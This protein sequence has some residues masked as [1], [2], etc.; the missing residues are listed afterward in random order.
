MAREVTD[1]KREHHEQNLFESQER[2]RFITDQVSDMI[3]THDVEG[4]WTY[5][6]PALKRVLGYDAS[7]VI[8]QDAAHFIHPDDKELALKAISSALKTPGVRPVTY[9]VR[10]KSGVYLWLESCLQSVR[11]SHTDRVTEIVAVSRDINR[12]KLEEEEQRKIMYRKMLHVQQT[13]LAVIEFTPTGEVV[14]WNPSAEQMFGWSR[15]QIV[16]KHFSIFVPEDQREEIDEVWTGLI[17]QSGGFRKAN[18]NIRSDGRRILCEWYNTPLIDADGTTVGVASLVQDVTDRRVA[19]EL[20]ENQRLQMVAAS[21]MS[22]LGEMAAGIAHEI[23]NPLAIILARAE[24]LRAAAERGNLDLGR[25]AEIS[26]RISATSDRIARIVSGLRFFARDGARD[27]F[28]KKPVASLVEETIAFC[29][30]RF[31]NH[32]VSL[33]MIPPE[34]AVTIECRPVQ[35]SQVLLNLLNNAFDAIQELPERWIRIAWRAHGDEVEIRI[36]D[37][38]PGIPANIADRIMTPFFTT[39]EIGKGT[40]LGLS[41]SRGIVE[42]H[43]GHLELVR[44]TAHTTFVIRLP[45]RQTVPMPSEHRPKS[46]H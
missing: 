7:E 6:N 46:I 2:Y 12:R 39:K 23:N 36:S 34:S 9:R 32:K 15:E 42:S 30:S 24:Q 3:H 33:E 19:E 20:I 38:G 37:S 21:K 14:E 1:V 25:V 28:E 22:A 45:A 17:S 27:S 41:I 11:D 18:A 40:G 31:H 16:G 13:P 4:K 44:D 26:E 29:K 35:M 5:V 10:T 8:G 43:D